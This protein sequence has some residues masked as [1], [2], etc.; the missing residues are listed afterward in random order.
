MPIWLPNHSSS[1]SRASQVQE[2]QAI[3]LQWM[4]SPHHCLSSDNHMG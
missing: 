2:K 3:L 1:P 4:F